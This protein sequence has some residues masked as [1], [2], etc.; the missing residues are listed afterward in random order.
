[1]SSGSGTA[2][3]YA[4]FD[5]LSAVRSAFPENPGC[6]RS[7]CARDNG[8][9]LVHICFVSIGVSYVGGARRDPELCFCHVG[10][11]MFD[12]DGA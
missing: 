1:M 7:E 2:D 12:D 11:I 9:L 10:T 3:H 6:I 4:L 5:V 8:E